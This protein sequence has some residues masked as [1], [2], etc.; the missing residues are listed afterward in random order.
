M[1]FSMKQFLL[2]RSFGT[3][4]A[5]PSRNSVNSLVVSKL[6]ASAPGE[7]AA[8]RA[9]IADSMGVYK[10]G[11]NDNVAVPFMK[12]M[13]YEIPVQLPFVLLSG[14]SMVALMQSWYGTQDNPYQ[15]VFEESFTTKCDPEALTEFYE[16][17]EL[18]HI[19]AVFPP[20]FDLFMSK[21]D[22]DTA[23]M[24]EETALLP[25]IE[26]EGTAGVEAEVHLNVK[27]LGMEVSFEIIKTEEEVDGEDVL[28][29]FCRHERFIDW[30]PLLNEWGTKIMLWD[31]TWKFE[32][33][34]LENGEYKVTHK[35]T[36]F[37]GPFPVRF[38]VWLHQ[39]YVIWACEKYINHTDFGV[40]DAD[41]D[42]QQAIIANI[43]FHLVRENT[44]VGTMQQTK[45]I[46]AM[47]ENFAPLT[48]VAMG[49]HETPISEFTHQVAEPN[50]LLRWNS[51]KSATTDPL[52]QTEFWRMDAVNR[53]MP[54]YRKLIKAPPK[55]ASED[56][57]EA[58][59]S[60]D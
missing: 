41:M 24:T 16:A 52:P 6:T 4:R 38:I 49:K 12:M 57:G 9:A 51:D 26:A 11:W 40:E 17:E 37:A 50:P 28:V 23:E 45:D 7:A 59:E 36:K 18:L 13:T 22:F 10:K 3:L 25:T 19:I 30:V 58:E 44:G 32:F 31:Q 47:R 42:E 2:K 53:R 20:F 39:K 46:N 27:T 54:G 15:P 8:S 56:S 43:P 1:A 33:D 5:T 29:H 35:C 48:Q 34:R 14:C 60:E 21:V 55:E